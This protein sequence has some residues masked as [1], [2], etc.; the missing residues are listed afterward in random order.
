[1]IRTVILIL[2]LCACGSQSDNYVQAVHNCIS[3]QVPTGKKVSAPVA[4]EAIRNC[5]TEIEH[6]AVEGLRERPG[7]QFDP[8]RPA[9]AREIQHRKE[10]IE[11]LL[12]TNLSDE[13]E[14]RTVIM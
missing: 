13:I 10:E 14:P 5:K 12:L 7:V 8:Q 9:I 4:H 3:D 1:M 6:W 11:D 2:S